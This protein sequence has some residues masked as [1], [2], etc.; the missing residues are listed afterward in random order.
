[1]TAKDTILLIVECDGVITS[2]TTHPTLLKLE[3]DKHFDV[4][5]SYS[6]IE[7]ATAENFDA[8]YVHIP[9]HKPIF[10]HICVFISLITHNIPTYILKHEAVNKVPLSVNDYTDITQN[11]NNLS[12]N[13]HCHNIATET[14]DASFSKRLLREMHELYIRK[15]VSKEYDLNTSARPQSQVENIFAQVGL[16]HDLVMRDEV[17][18]KNTHWCYPLDTITG[19]IVRSVDIRLA[20][21]HF[22]SKL[23]KTKE[24]AT[25]L[26]VGAG[27]GYT[28]H[29]L[30]AMGYRVE[31][32]EL[33]A[34]R[35][36]GAQML[37]T[38]KKTT[39]NFTIGNLSNL[40][41]EDC[42]FDIVF[43]CFVL[44]QCQEILEEAIS[45][46]LRVAKIK[47]VFFEPSSEHYP[48][49]PSIIHNCI[50]GQP[51]NLG[52]RLQ[53][54]GYKV[55]IVKPRFQHYYNSGCMFIVD[56]CED[57]GNHNYQFTGTVLGE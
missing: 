6:L 42:S 44:E 9:S 57:Q 25:F 15:L 33:S 51:P 45:E 49:L 16:A 18:S 27:S 50:E 10:F 37:G 48:T 24:D 47:C 54:S 22:L 55:H 19:K 21:A 34:Y 28:T 41:Y 36:K 26:E 40:P 52:E 2:L 53:M 11:I 31:G 5:D 30:A 32:S 8:V 12:I 7:K 43:S 3:V 23:V 35:V 29:Y 39:T 56:K 20:Y 38:L 1:M 13:F 17:L 46:C 4:V 14:L